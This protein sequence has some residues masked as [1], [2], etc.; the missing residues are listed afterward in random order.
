VSLSR[1]RKEKGEGA[2]SGRLIE[3]KKERE[4]TIG[5]CWFWGEKKRKKG[6]LL[7]KNVYPGG[8]KRGGSS[9]PLPTKEKGRGELLHP[10]LKKAQGPLR[11]GK[12]EKKLMHL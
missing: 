12:K 6:Q 8:R 9:F 11:R 10:Y 3:P 1:G 7:V 5:L 2:I 4:D